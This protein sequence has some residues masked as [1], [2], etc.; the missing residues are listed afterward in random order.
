VDT[1]RRAAGFGLLAYG[2]ITPIALIIGK[3][4]GGDYE[5]RAIATYISSGHR[6]SAIALAFLGGFAALG[7]LIFANR[8][9]HELRSGGDLL[10]GLVIIGTALAVIG[11]FL[12]GGIAVALA[13][14]GQSLASGVPHPVVY[15]L[16][17]MSI[18]VGVVSR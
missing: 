13:M 7:L 10:W 12:L 16:S 17:I 5:D 18:M 15:L 2:I 1:S 8:M 11:W 9:R 14:G 4:P 3:V 6:A